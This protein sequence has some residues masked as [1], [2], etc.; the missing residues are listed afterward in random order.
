MRK[1]IFTILFFV[2]FFVLF[3][4][5]TVNAYENK[6]YEFRAAWVA[7]VF[8]IDW[9]SQKGLS[10]NE[11]KQEF[12]NIVENAKSMNLN[13]LIVQ[14]RPTADAFYKSSL[15]PYSEFLTGQEG[16]N[17]GY[18]PLEFMISTCHANSI[19]FHAW[20]NP[21]RVTNSKTEKA[22]APN[23]V[24]NT[25]KDWI[26]DYEGKKYINPGIPEARAFVVNSI[27]EVVKN[28]D[29]DAIH[30]DDYFYPY[31]SKNPFPDD[32]SFAM[33]GKGD[34]K[35]WRRE[36]IN[37]FMKSV[38]ETVKT[39]KHYVR[40]GVSPFGVWR[41]IENDITGS[42]T[43]AGVSSYDS[44]NADIRFWIEQNWI[45]Y[46]IPQIY[47]ERSNTRTPYNTL[48]DYWAY[49]NLKNPDLHLYI[50]HASYR[51]NDW[52][53]KKEIQSQLIFNRYYKQTKGSAF[54][55]MTSLK[56]NLSG[57]TDE[58]KNTYFKYKAIVPPYKNSDEVLAKVEI[59]S[60]TNNIISFKTNNKNIKYFVVYKIS[61]GVADIN[62]PA[63]I[64]KFINNNTQ[65]TFTKEPNKN[66]VITAINRYNNESPAS[67]V[68]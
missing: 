15:N 20:F 9:P 63:N 60:K 52:K 66:Y 30:F 40:V 67:D 65:N 25:H 16:K 56:N 22:F 50:G 57:F 48:V 35:T 43:N 27:A 46:V 24:V 32:A 1:L 18:D 68:F 45:D 13:A 55:N 7:T 38:Y 47:W 41:N 26:V 23:S 61:N 5:S 44:L 6:K 11:Q 19:E 2:L 51:I 34:K 28:Y 37:S 14:I 17:P 42:K 36:N 53:D 58:L 49:E 39:E 8:N 33:Y 10:V 4:S 54:Y 12:I 62:N 29:I 64:V 31:P 3:S 59:V 21:F